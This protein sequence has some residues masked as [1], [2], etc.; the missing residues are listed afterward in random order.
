MC[1]GE[2][3]LIEA[4]SRAIVPPG[5]ITGGV[6]ARGG[7]KSS[8]EDQGGDEGRACLDDF[9]GGKNS[10]GQASS[11]SNRFRWDSALRQSLLF[12][13]VEHGFRVATQ[14]GT[15][16]ELK[17]PFFKDWFESVHNLRHW[18]DGDPF[19][20]NYV[21]HPL[22]G[23]VSGFIQVQNDPRGIKLTPGLNRAYVRSRPRALGWSAIYSTQF[24]LG[25][26]GESSIGN[27]GLRPYET[28]R[29]P[30]AFVDMV[31]SPVFGTAWLVGEDLIDQKLIRRIESK[32]TNR[33]IR[34]VARSL[35][36]PSR[37]FANLMRG[38]WFWYRDDR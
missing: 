24:E 25:P 2:A 9:D 4:A 29:R 12:L 17:G 11:D 6:T 1:G 3:I 5:D 18:R 33:V 34:I 7:S 26:L 22:Q 23:A 20:V 36:N 19:Y 10:A 31:I 38:R 15:R 28:S 8:S 35:L 13:L 27:V 16:A 37:S 21:G 30:Q 14:P 32:T